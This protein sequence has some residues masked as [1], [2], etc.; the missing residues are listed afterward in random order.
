MLRA[1][2]RDEVP[3]EGFS[4]EAAK[5]RSR[6]ETPHGMGTGRVLFPLPQEWTQPTVRAQRWWLTKLTVRILDRFPLTIRTRLRRVL[7]AMGV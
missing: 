3:E 4:K 6:P 2:A 1:M 5:A 7:R